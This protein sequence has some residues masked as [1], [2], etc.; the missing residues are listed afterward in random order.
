MGRVDCRSRRSP[1]PTNRRP[2]A[3]RSIGNCSRRSRRRASC[4]RRS[5]MPR[6]FRRRAT[7]SSTACCRSTSRIEFLQRLSTRCAARV[8]RTAASWPIGTTVVRALEHSAA[9]SR[10]GRRRRRRRRPAH[11]RADAVARRRCDPVR[12]ARA[13]HEP[14]RAAARV[15]RRIDSAAAR[16]ARSTAGGFRTHEFGD[17]VLIERVATL[18]ERSPTLRAEDFRGECKDWSSVRSPYTSRF[19]RAPDVVQ[20]SGR[21]SSAGRLV[22]C[23]G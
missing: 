12:H 17:S 4:S 6:V 20:E 22:G 13:G 3:S 18:F 16:I 11:R 14:L 9:R 1:S 8:A 15:R 2:R 23:S 19:L 10:R 21:L 5:R 7:P